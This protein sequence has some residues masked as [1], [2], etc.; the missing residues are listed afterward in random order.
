MKGPEGMCDNLPE[1]VFPG[2]SEIFASRKR[3]GEGR[4][5]CALSCIEV[6]VSSAA[7][8]SNWHQAEGLQNVLNVM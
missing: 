5:A 7:S 3:Q 1:T 8:G 4:L 2:S 6:A